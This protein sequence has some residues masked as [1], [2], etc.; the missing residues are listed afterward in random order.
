ML[1]GFDKECVNKMS[2]YNYDYNKYCLP[3]LLPLVRQNLIDKIDKKNWTN[4]INTFKTN[5]N[6]L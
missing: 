3:I 6:G 5:I 1:G 4:N 2:L